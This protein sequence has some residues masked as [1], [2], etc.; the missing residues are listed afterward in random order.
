MNKYEILE[1][2]LAKI[3]EHV[4]TMQALSDASMNYLKQFKQ[5]VE[6]LIIA[7]QNK[8]IRSSEGAVMG[9]VRSI[10]DYD[11]ICSDEVLWNLVTDADNYYCKECRIF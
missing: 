3:I 11:E 4:D 8:T 2:K 1:N 6:K 9:L 7:I 10:S 5:Y